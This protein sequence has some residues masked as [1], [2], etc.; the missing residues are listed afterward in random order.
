MAGTR[1]VVDLRGITTVRRHA[2]ER[3]ERRLAPAEPRN[4]ASGEDRTGFW[5]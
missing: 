2:K 4:E 3:V 1:A 5:R